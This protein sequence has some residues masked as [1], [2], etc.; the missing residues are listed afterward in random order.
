VRTKF[1]LLAFTAVGEAAVGIALL[2]SPPIMVHLL[3]AAVITGVGIVMSR[4]A[5][6]AL[7]AL[8]IACWPPGGR[9]RA[10]WAMLTYSALATVYLGYLGVRGEWAGPLLWPV[11]ALH[12][13]LT[14]LL[15]GVWF[16]R[17]TL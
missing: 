16:K 12:A 15:A 4:I 7:I 8:G 11:V 3:F 9:T 2:V 6:I 5:G 14:L 10:L 13:L 17:P 1:P